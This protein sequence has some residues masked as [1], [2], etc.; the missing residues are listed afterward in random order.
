[1]EGFVIVKKMGKEEVKKKV[2]YFFEKVGLVD[3]VDL[4]LF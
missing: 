3:K 4:Y 2:N 1:M